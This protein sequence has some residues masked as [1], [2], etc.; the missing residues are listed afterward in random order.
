[1]RINVNSCLYIKHEGVINKLCTMYDLS[2]SFMLDM[3]FYLMEVIKDVFQNLI[4]Y[5][6]IN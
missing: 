2:H 4:Q 3:N 1:M 5:L 6:E